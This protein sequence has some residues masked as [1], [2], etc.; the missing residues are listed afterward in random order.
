MPPG[1]DVGPAEARACLRHVGTERFDHADFDI[2]LSPDDA[3]FGVW[4]RVVS[5]EHSQMRAATQARLLAG[6]RLGRMPGATPLREAEMRWEVAVF[7][8]LTRKGGRL[9][10]RPVQA[11][12]FAASVFK[13]S[14]AMPSYSEG[15]A[16][17]LPFAAAAASRGA[18]VTKTIARS[19]IRI[20]HDPEERDDAR[21]FRR[22]KILREAPDLIAAATGADL[23]W[24]EIAMQALDGLFNAMALDDDEALR[25]A[26]A[27]LDSP[28]I[29]WLARLKNPFLK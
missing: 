18:M 23:A 24:L 11:A 22:D 14:G 7:G 10:G 5:T 13:K 4:R 2:K 19:G 1:V 20:E 17:E 16:V 29:G 15:E 28:V 27:V 9:H 8:M 12:E 6:H 21:K 3:R 25:R 26:I